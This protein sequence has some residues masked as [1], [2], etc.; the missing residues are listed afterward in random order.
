MILRV[1]KFVVYDTILSNSF[2]GALTDQ[3]TSNALKIIVNLL[4]AA[5]LE[6]C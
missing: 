4:T 1:A 3:V 6:E 5:A 2:D